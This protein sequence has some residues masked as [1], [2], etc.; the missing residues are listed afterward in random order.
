M[1]FFH[2]GSLDAGQSRKLST[3]KLKNKANPRGVPSPAR[4]IPV[5][6]KAQGSQL[7]VTHSER[8]GDAQSPLKLPT[9]PASQKESEAGEVGIN[10]LDPGQAV[11]RSNFRLLEGC[12]GQQQSLG[13]ISLASIS[14]SLHSSLG[15]K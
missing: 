9:P 2:Q 5:L 13:A 7:R 10:L 6:P 1:W 12:N 14:L 11:L 4:G 15:A 3:P 8:R